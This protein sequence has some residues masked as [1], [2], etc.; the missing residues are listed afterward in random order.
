[1]GGVRLALDFRF[2]AL[3]GDFSWSLHQKSPKTFSLAPL[4]LQRAFRSLQGSARAINTRTTAGISVL[5]WWRS[6][7]HV[8]CE[9]RL[10]IRTCS[11]AEHRDFRQ[12]CVINYATLL[13]Y[14]ICYKML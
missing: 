6:I 5:R 14:G 13:A 1:M 3:L 7:V 9:Y 10:S 2:R 11:V 4:E 12:D 8:Y